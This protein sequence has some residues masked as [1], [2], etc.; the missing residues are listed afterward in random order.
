MFPKKI[1]TRSFRKIVF[2]G[3]R[4]VTSDGAQERV[5][6]LL[7]RVHSLDAYSWHFPSQWMG[8][9]TIQLHSH[10]I[11]Q[12]LEGNCFVF[13]MHRQFCISLFPNRLDL[14]EYYYYT[15]ILL[16]PDLCCSSSAILVGSCKGLLT[17]GCVGSLL[18]RVK[19]LLNG[20][21]SSLCDTEA[22]LL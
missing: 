17:R 1:K 2:R 12:V 21:L 15:E 4:G 9:T 19:V 22:C 5:R 7:S 3:T 18:H 6:Q 16:F 20:L 11:L 8:G 13:S 14:K 10:F